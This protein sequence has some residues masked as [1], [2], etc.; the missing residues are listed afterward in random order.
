M[1]LPRRGVFPANRRLSRISGAGTFTDAREPPLEV[2]DIVR[3]NSGGINMLVVDAWPGSPLITVA[4]KVRGE[5][6]AIAV[7]EWD[8]A[9][10]VVHRVRDAW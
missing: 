3:L 6:G 8:V 5:K 2:G 10:A 1:S 9:R 4:F 7:R